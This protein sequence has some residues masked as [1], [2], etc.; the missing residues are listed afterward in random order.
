MTVAVLGLG[1]IGMRHA[2]N[3]RALGRDVAGFDP[4]PARRRQ[5]EDEGGQAFDSRAAA[6]E[7]AN[8]VVVA[9]PSERHLDDMRAAVDAGRHLFVEK[10]LAHTAD[11]VAEV[12]ADARDAGLTVFPGLVLRFHPAVLAA[13]DMLRQGAVGTPIWARF[14]MSD[15]LP[16]WR[17]HQDHRAGYAADPRTGGVLFD[18][19][20][21]F[22]IANFLLGPAETAAAAARSSGLLEIAA[23]DCADVVL[24]HADGVLSSMHFDYL[25]RPRR[26]T[27]EIAGSDG[28]IRLDLD[29]RRLNVVGPDGDTTEDRVFP[30]DYPD[31]FLRQMASFLA[32]ADGDEAPPCTGDEALAVLTQVLDA[33]RLAGLPSTTD[34]ETAP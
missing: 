19:V 26:R 14:Q 20:H 12:L 30:G 2:R 6:L 33:R 25:T 31:D 13:R 3:L 7:R 34:H 10:P 27:T 32:C 15:Y 16:N 4:D 22:D 9:S 24:R 23:E 5:L 29:A 8:A 1:S 17:P 28:I 11:G 21:E 18:L